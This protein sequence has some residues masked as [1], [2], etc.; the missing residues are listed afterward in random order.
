MLCG[1]LPIQKSWICGYPN[2][3]DCVV[4]RTINLPDVTRVQG[5]QYIAMTKLSITRNNLNLK[6]LYEHCHMCTTI[7][8]LDRWTVLKLFNTRT[9]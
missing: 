7:K 3:Q 1:Q 5:D 4:T 2:Q 9:V 8:T 6:E